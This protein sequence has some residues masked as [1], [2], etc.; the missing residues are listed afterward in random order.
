VFDLRVLQQETRGIHDLRDAGLVVGPEQCGPV[1]RD[2]VVADLMGERRMIREADHLR[3]IRRQRDVLAL[4]VLDELG[5][6]IG[7]AA[8]G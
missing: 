4:V 5:P 2:D 8:I 6:D 1:G 7:A 3:G